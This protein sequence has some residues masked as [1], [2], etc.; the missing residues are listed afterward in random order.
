MVDD[1]LAR[2]AYER[3]L[4][5]HWEDKTDDPINL[6]LGKEDGLY[7]HHY[8]VGEFDRRVLL[9]DPT[10]RE[11]RILSEMH[12]L[13]TD[14]VKLILDG[15]GS[16]SASDRILDGG[17]GRGGTSFMIH[18]RFRCHVEG[19][20]FC[21]HQ[22]QFAQNLSLKRGCESHVKFHHAN[23]CN[24]RF[25]SG[26]FQA[27]VTNETTMYVNLVEAF[28]EFARLLVPG[29]R[30]TGVTWCWN[31]TAGGRTEDIDAIDRHYVCNINPRSAYFAAMHEA[32]LV[33]LR[34][35]D[36]TKDAIPYWELRSASSLRTGVEPYF[37]SGHR[38]NRLQYMAFTAERV[39]EDE[40]TLRA[41]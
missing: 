32:G 16:I 4:H 5:K 17:S 35:L 19:V 39:H 3:E 10:I 28:T 26:S 2:T 30:Y 25:R 14:Q 15:L 13:E 7:H 38:S 31:D 20:N 1:R 36:L 41:N 8:A 23:M 24:T 11:Q 29:G 6:L 40:Q 12:R 37:L 21:K 18:D 27:V 22:V 9:S 33:P 34:V